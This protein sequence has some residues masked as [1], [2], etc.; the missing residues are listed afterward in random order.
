MQQKI[1]MLF[2]IALAG[3]PMIAGAVYMNSNDAHGAAGT[4]FND[5]DWFREFNHGKPGKHEADLNRHPLHTIPWQIFHDATLDIRH[6][7]LK[8]LHLDKDWLQILKDR[9]DWIFDGH[10]GPHARVPEPATL[11]L[12]A[13]GILLI[14]G[15][16]KS[17][18]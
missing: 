17:R 14:A 11:V 15:I 18:R 5:D 2:L 9:L 10:A 16:R 3:F 12:L 8:K 1:R 6:I 7:D 4:N 13:T